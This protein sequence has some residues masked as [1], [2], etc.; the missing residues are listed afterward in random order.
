MLLVDRPSS[1][2]K[3]GETN[4]NYKQS[5]INIDWPANDEWAG[6]EESSR[7]VQ[8]RPLPQ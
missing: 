5:A 2:K 1:K 4:F 6:C 3:A 8:I 7:E